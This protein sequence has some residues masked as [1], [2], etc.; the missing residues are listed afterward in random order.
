MLTYKQ[1]LIGSKSDGQL[2]SPRL[3]RSERFQRADTGLND[4]RDSRQGGDAFCWVAA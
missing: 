3:I 1:Q 4:Q 2:S